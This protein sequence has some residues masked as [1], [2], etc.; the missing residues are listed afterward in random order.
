[1]RYYFHL[2][3]QLKILNKSC[4]MTKPKKNQLQ[5]KLLSKQVLL[6]FLLGCSSYAEI[7]ASTNRKKELNLK[8]AEIEFPQQNITVTGKIISIE[9]NMPVPGVNIN[10]KGTKNGVVTDFDGN[11]KITVPSSDAILV[12]TSLGYAT[13]E[14]KVGPQRSINIILKTAMSDLKEVVVVGYG[15]KKKESLTG[16]VEQIKAVTFKDRAVSN[17]ALALQGATPGLVVTR[18]SARPGNEGIGLQI[19]GVTSINGGDPLVIIDGSP[20]TGLRDFYQMSPNDIESISVLK[21]GSAAIYGSRAANGVI[22]VTTKKGKGKIKVEYGNNYKYNTIGIRPPAPTMEQYA[23]SFLNAY[24]QDGINTIWGWG[25]TD[26]LLKMQQ[27]VEGIYTTALWGDVFIGKANRFDEMFGSSSSI[28]HNVSV[29]GSSD[30]SKFRLSAEMNDTRGALKTAYDGQ[31]NYSIRFNYDYDISKRVSLSSNVVYQHS[32]ISGPT[33]GLNVD[34]IST[35]PPFFPAKNP[36]GQW[37]ANFNIAGNRN[38]TAATIDGGRT[39]FGEDLFKVVLSTKINLAK[40]FDFTS[41][42]AYNKRVSREDKYALTIQPYT[43]FGELSAEK[44]NPTSYV[45]ARVYD[46]IYQNYS[47]FLNYEI[48]KGGHKFTTKAGLTTDLQENGYLYAERKNVPDVGIYDINI[49][50]ITANNV[51]NG[52]TRDHWGLYSYL[53]TLGYD[54]RDKYLVDFV[55]RKDGSSRFSAANRWRNFGS[56][57]AGWVISKENFLE[58]S[59]IINFLKLRG[60]YG[61]MGNQVGV[62]VYDYLSSISQGTLPFGESP[63][64]QSTARVGSITSD[65]RTWESV[66]MKNIG[67]DFT[68]FNNRLSG[69][70]DYYQ[71][72]NDGMFINTTYPVVLGGTAPK[73]NSGILDTKGWEAMLSWKDTKG[74]FSYNISFNIGDSR[75]ELVKMEGATNW[76]AGKVGTRV[77]YPINSYF[78]YQ[79]DG[80]FQTQADLDAYIAQ[81]TLVNQGEIPSAA[82][83]LLRLGDTKKV[84]LDGNGYIS[85]TGGVGDKGDVKYMGDAAAHYVYGLNMGASYKNFDFSAFFQGALNQYVLRTGYL[86]QPFYAI[87]TNQTSAYLG[88]TW[89]A[90]NTSAQYPRL[91]A[92]QT[93]SRYNW[94]NNDF[95]LQN[96]RYIRLKSLVV[97]YNIP[98]SLVDK[99][100]VDK[101]RIYFS[102]ND[103]FEL[104]AVKDGFDP[105]YGESSNNI[106]PFARTWSVGLNVS[107]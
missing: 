21:D 40:G 67:L 42:A 105:E 3:N 66:A 44:I 60:S 35:D 37:Y 53:A 75:N 106:Y 39:N 83:S 26:N 101:L 70:F 76:S 72:R 64:N 45:A 28:Q 8:V 65:T 43:W 84:D 79:T 62:G 71:K 19:R 92:D 61:T 56:V 9:D 95:M 97:G 5:L 33:S 15:T 68:V 14:V 85:A 20:V 17:P 41:T 94:M 23:T 12:F 52:S 16:A 102:G 4:S 29:S 89:T 80:F 54:Y 74:D 32:L 2:S 73:S 69:S 96:N 18:G 38:G 57:S 91:T 88:K 87:W 1:M 48:N 82:L 100:K 58:D 50:P 59:S 34:A 63:A 7:Y 81:Y 47:A 36:F 104:T 30:V 6:V 90:E 49:V 27:G 11:Y 77:G 98:Q 13:Q 86:S 31:K 22:L 107:F 99:L 78:L 103:L 51:V 10:V 93:R 24:Q 25:T 55:G 46:I